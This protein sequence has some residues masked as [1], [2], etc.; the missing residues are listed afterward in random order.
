MYIGLAG[1]VSASSCAR[2]KPV[3]DNAATGMIGA[4]RESTP[5]PLGEE[6]LSHDYLQKD[7]VCRSNPQALHQWRSARVF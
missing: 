7:T 6:V 1:V 2:T 5:R 4:I 3:S